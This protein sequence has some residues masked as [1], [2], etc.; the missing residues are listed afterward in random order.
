MLILTEPVTHIAM[1]V[2]KLLCEQANFR[3][4]NA[5]ATN[6]YPDN[7]TMRF[8]YELVDK[9][10]IENLIEKCQAVSSEPITFSPT[11]GITAVDKQSLDDACA[12]SV[13]AVSTNVADALKRLLGEKA[14]VCY[15]KP[16]WLTDF[17]YQDLD[18]KMDQIADL[19]ILL[20]RDC[21]V[22]K[23]AKEVASKYTTRAMMRGFK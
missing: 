5:Y 9:N 2:E 16:D 12:K 21:P 10:Q 17:P 4:V 3:K 8:C 13:V 15:I 23:V 7:D 18:R 1:E 19:N 14:V 22:E 6:L 11:L 20:T